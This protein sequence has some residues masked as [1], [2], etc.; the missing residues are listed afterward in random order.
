MQKNWILPIL[1]AIG[2]CVACQPAVTAP[3]TGAPDADRSPVASSSPVHEI[4]APTPPTVVVTETPAPE[5]TT[6]LTKEVMFLAADGVSLAGTLFGEGDRAIVLAHQGTA[7]ADQTS[8]HPFAQVLAE[9]G[10]AALAF[11]F[12]GVGRSSGRVGERALDQDL[13]AAVQLLRDLGYDEIV[14]VGASMGGTACLRL[15]VDEGF[16]GLATLGSAMVA[17]RGDPVRV[18]DADLKLLSLPKLFITAEGDNYTV[19]DH[20][21]HMFEA[22]PEPKALH[23]LPGEAHGTDLFNT[24]QGDAL[25]EILLEFLVSL[26]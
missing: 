9:H 4:A 25:T 26:P 16:A 2:A 5:E 24:E 7:G 6:T 1:C 15:A 10:F 12:R 8:W 21:K 3:P 17:G 22:S 19:V 18:S 23:L 13:A 14:C 11:D 20:T